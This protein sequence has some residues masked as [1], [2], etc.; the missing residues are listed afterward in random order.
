[1]AAQFWGH[2]NDAAA[3][4]AILTPVEVDDMVAVGLDERVETLYLRGRGECAVDRAT[5]RT[6]GPSIGVTEGGKSVLW[7]KPIRKYKLC[8]ILKCDMRTATAWLKKR[9]A[10]PKDGSNKQ[11]I[12]IDLNA[13]DDADRALFAEYEPCPAI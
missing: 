6:P 5:R 10:R 3:V 9:G 4:R 11:V 2:A 1:L 12:L 13:L 7:S 8:E